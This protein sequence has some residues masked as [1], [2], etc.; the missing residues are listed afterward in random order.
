MRTV[1]RHAVPVLM[2]GMRSVPRVM[3]IIVMVVRVRHEPE[4]P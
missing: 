4:A 3:V 2:S 1:A